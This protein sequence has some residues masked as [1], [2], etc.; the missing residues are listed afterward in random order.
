MEMITQAKIDEL[1]ALSSDTLEVKATAHQITMRLAAV[2]AITNFKTLA[3]A[4]RAGHGASFN[5]ST[6]TLTLPLIPKAE[7]VPGKMA[8]GGGEQI[9]VCRV[10]GMILEINADT[11]EQAIAGCPHNID[12][13]IKLATRLGGKKAKVYTSTADAT[14]ARKASKK[15]TVPAMG[16][17]DMDMPLWDPVKNE[18]YDGELESSGNG[19]MRYTGSRN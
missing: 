5:G 4:G 7:F 15:P 14:R 1:N 19:K 13:L 12:K 18:W 16:P 3:A 11:M 8:L 17:E 2:V 6:K 9:P 10:R